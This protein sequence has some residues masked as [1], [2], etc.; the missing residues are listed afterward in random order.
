MQ[1]KSQFLIKVLQVYLKRR[2]HSIRNIR[3]ETKLQVEF[4]NDILR[5]DEFF[6]NRTIKNIEQLFKPKDL[7]M[8]MMVQD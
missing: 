3:Q 2:I 1:V 5:K 8:I 7:K 4:I 6:H